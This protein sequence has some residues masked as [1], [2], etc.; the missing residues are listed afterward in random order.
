MPESADIDGQRRFL[1]VKEVGFRL[2]LSRHAI[3]RLIESGEL[4]SHRFGRAVR[5]DPVD[6]EEFIARSKQTP[7]VDG[8]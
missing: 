2:N 7:A 4:P 3:Y 1:T 8:D 6:V 5:L